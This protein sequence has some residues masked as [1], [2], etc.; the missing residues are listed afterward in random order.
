MSAKGGLSSPMNNP[1]KTP[2]P[3]EADMETGP[4]GPVNRRPDVVSSPQN[5]PRRD[6]TGT[7]ESEL[8]KKQ[9]Y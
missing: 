2:K 9:G 7:R 3:R 8:G 6:S 4:K 5:G 1:Y